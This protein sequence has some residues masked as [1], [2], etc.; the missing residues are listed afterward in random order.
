MQDNRS[1]FTLVELAVVLTIIGLIIGGALTGRDLIRSA[2]LNTMITNEQRFLQGV[3]NFREKY[4]ALPGDMK[5]ATQYWGVLGGNGTGNDI[6]CQN[7]SA[8]AT[9]T[10]NGNGNGKIGMSVVNYDEQLRFWQ[11]LANAGM[12]EGQYTGVQGSPVSWLPGT[13]IPKTKLDGIGWW[14]VY[15][16]SFAGSLTQFAVNFSHVFQFT[17]GSGSGQILTPLD[18]FRIDSKADDGAPGTGKVVAFKGN[19]TY[20]CTNKYN[21]AAGSDAGAVYN[22]TTV[23]TQACWQIFDA[24]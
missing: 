19:A 10:C 23:L 4:S 7:L 24:F 14:V 15:Y 20:Q 17:N 8:T 16:G 5:N 12:I 21:V 2:E 3:Q 13:N 22:T 9:A 1:A 6:A 18:A 11:H